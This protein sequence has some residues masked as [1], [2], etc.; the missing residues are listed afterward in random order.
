M[1]ELNNEV[2][3][4][5]LYWGKIRECEKVFHLSYDYSSDGYDYDEKLRISVSNLGN[6]LQKVADVFEFEFERKY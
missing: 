1:Q 5:S 4:S 6:Y 3:F 2:F